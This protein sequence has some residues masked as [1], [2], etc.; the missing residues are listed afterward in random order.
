MSHSPEPWIAGCWEREQVGHAVF[1]VFRTKPQDVHSEREVFSGVKDGDRVHCSEWRKNKVS[2]ECVIGLEGEYSG[3][4]LLFEAEDM[5]RVV[6][7]VNACKGIPTEALVAGFMEWIAAATYRI[8][9]CV[10][11]PEDKAAY[12]IDEALRRARDLIQTVEN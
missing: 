8:G 1:Y 6:A 3:T 5:D 7:C 12:G 11:P 4:R 9:G 10:K 2:G